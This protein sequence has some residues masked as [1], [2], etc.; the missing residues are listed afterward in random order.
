VP[1]AHAQIRHTQVLNCWQASAI[2]ATG[3]GTVKRYPTKNGI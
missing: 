1:D 3:S 2:F